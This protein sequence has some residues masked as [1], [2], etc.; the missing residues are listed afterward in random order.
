MPTPIF[1]CLDTY[2][3]GDIILGNLKPAFLAK[4]NNLT[5]KDGFLI[6]PTKWIQG[7]KMAF[8]GLKNEKDR[9]SVLLYINSQSDSPLELP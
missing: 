8:A 6:K 1:E 5:L 4:L 3:A 2:A 7:T 9:A